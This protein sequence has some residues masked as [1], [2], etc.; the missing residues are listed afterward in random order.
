MFCVR[1]VRRGQRRGPFWLGIFGIGGSILLGIYNFVF[2][3]IGIRAPFFD[4]TT[5]GHQHDSD[6]L[7]LVLVYCTIVTCNLF[8]FETFAQNPDSV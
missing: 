2:G 4:I 5:L 8:I 6:D 3:R 7:L 1:K